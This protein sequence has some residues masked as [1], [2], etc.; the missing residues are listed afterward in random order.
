M[1]FPGQIDPRFLDG[2]SGICENA[3]RL[4]IAEMAHKTHNI[5]YGTR[6]MLA[7][8]EPDKPGYDPRIFECPTC[9]HSERV[10]VKLP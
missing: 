2:R 7:P 6:I 3:L 1:H 4:R 8:T 5:K 10:V 9:E